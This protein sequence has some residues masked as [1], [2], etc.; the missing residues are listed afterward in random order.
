MLAYGEYQKD[1]II[2][3]PL[4]H[5]SQGKHDDLVK[6]GA[7]TAHHVL[8]TMLL[9]LVTNIR[10]TLLPAVIN[11]N[12]LSAYTRYYESIQPAYIRCSKVSLAMYSNVH[13]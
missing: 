2:I 11:M 8:V 10:Q 12:M 9:Y 3:H 7:Q 5:I 4:I 1:Y 13:I 6:Y